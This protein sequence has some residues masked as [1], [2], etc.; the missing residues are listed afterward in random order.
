MS[1]FF[2]PLAKVAGVLLLLA[3]VGGAATTS[4]LARGSAWRAEKA[5]WGFFLGLGL[6]AGMVPLSLLVGARPGW[7][8]MI[9]VASLALAAASLFRLRVIGADVP[10]PPVPNW[11]TRLLWWMLL[12]GVALYALRALTEPMWSNDYLAIWGFKGKTIFGAAGIPSRLFQWQSLSFSHP[13]YPLGLPFLYAGL[14]FLLGRFDDHALALAFP[15]IEIATLLVLF[16]WLRRRGAPWP[17]PLA[18]AALLA[19]FEPLYSGFLTGMAEVP[20]SC[21]ILLF[22]TAL[23]DS[24]DGSDTDPAATRRLAAASFLVASTKNEGLFVAVAAALL[25][26]ILASCKKRSVRWTVAAAA[27]LPGAG[28][29]A[30]SQLLRGSVPLRDFDFGLLTAGRFG[31]LPARLAESLRTALVDVAL[32]AWLG[33]VCVAVLLAAGRHTAY[34]DRLLLLAAVCLAAYVLLPALAVPGPTWLV[35]TTFARTAAALAPLVAAGIA[36]RMRPA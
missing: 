11:I 28:V 32:P 25:A 35:R 6:A 36:G 5:G 21:E 16:G 8:P 19:L 12:C 13:E 2:L 15:G 3:A 31:E 23:A 18:A 14:A 24:L 33:L 27:L 17:L 9:V 29:A 7:A 22:G 4:L 34:A 20:L 30:L 1:L 26:V 10:P